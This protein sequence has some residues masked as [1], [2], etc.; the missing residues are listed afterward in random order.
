MSLLEEMLRIRDQHGDL[1]P[2]IVVEEAADPG[3]PLH[4]YFEWDESEAARQYR[5]VQASGLIRRVKVT[6][7]RGPDVEP[8]RV[9]AF[10]SRQELSGEDEREAGSYEY[11]VDVVKDDVARTVWFQQMQRDWLRLKRKYEVHKEFADMV[12][13]DLRDMAG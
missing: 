3:S 12:L 10:V 6:V 9:R 11:V 2:D 7:E 13:G 1:R 5:L 8:I 4:T